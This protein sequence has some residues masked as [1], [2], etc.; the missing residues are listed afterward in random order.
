MSPGL[1]LGFKTLSPNGR[2]LGGTDSTRQIRVQLIWGLFE[3]KHLV[4]LEAKK[5]SGKER[6]TLGAAGTTQ[7]HKDRSSAWVQPTGGSGVTLWS[8]EPYGYQR[9]PGPLQLQKGSTR[10]CTMLTHTHGCRETRS[11]SEHMALSIRTA[12]M[13]SGGDLHPPS[14][15]NFWGVGGCTTPNCFCRSTKGR[16]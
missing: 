4:A 8:L 1:L 3:Q 6:Q 11:C 9:Q 12:G 7:K 13:K 10:P 15:P 5:Q 2:M 16:F 14:P